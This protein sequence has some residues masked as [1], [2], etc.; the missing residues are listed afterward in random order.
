MA[1]GGAEAGGDHAERSEKGDRRRARVTNLS[2]RAGEGRVP[3]ERLQAWAKA[4]KVDNETFG[5]TLLRFYDPYMWQMLY[6][7]ERIT[8]E[9]E[10]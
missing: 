10:R 5:K 7:P 2:D 1:T 6:G 8:D 4:I 3:P 9:E